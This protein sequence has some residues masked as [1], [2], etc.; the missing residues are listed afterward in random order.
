MPLPFAI[1]PTV[2]RRPA[3]SRITAVCFAKVSVVMM[4]VAASSPVRSSSASTASGMAP[5]SLSTGNGTPITPVDATITSS[6]AHPRAFASAS[7]VATASRSPCA[8]VHAL[9]FPALMMTARAM[10]PAI[11]RRETVTGAA[12]TWLVVKTPAAGTGFSATTSARSRFP[13]ALSPAATPEA[14]KPSGAATPP[15]A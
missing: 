6:G 13:S 3:T 7:A 15:W 8:P 12:A 9:A 10:P 1:P 11:W 2:M 5:R 4:A 14:V